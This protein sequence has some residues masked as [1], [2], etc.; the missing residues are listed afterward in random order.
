MTIHIDTATYLAPPVGSV[1][2]CSRQVRRASCGHDV[3][4]G[5]LGVDA[6]DRRG[7]Q[8]VCGP[9]YVKRMEP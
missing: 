5:P 1:P 4:I 3:Y 6:V 9:C 2:S 8:L 7:K